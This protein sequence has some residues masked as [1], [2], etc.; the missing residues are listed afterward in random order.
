MPELHHIDLAEIFGKMR[1]QA[2]LPPP[3]E[4]TSP[5]SS[6]RPE[7]LLCI[8]LATDGF[9]DNWQYEDVTKF[10][11]DASCVNAVK[12]GGNGAARVAASF[13]RRNILYSKKNFGGH[14]DNSTG[15]LVY[16][17]EPGGIPN[18]SEFVKPV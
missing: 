8:V 2:E 3:T 10:V 7:P 14:A 18:G 4:P 16:L 12:N 1:L 6:L 13:M 11:M 17:S 5:S 9:W 15:I